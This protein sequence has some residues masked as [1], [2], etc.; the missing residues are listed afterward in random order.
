M[1]KESSCDLSEDIRRDVKGGSR[2]D[3]QK[4]YDGGVETVTLAQ[5]DLLGRIRV[6]NKG[7]TLQKSIK[8]GVHITLHEL[9]LSFVSIRSC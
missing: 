3:V 1:A 8:H 7:C 6:K 4:R 5:G 9:S 2:R